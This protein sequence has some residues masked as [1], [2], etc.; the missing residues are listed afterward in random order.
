MSAG[1]FG[2]S[3]PG[4]GVIGGRKGYGRGAGLRVNPNSTILWDREVMLQPRV[5]EQTVNEGAASSGSHEIGLVLST[6]MINGSQDARMLIPALLASRVSTAVIPASRDS[7][8]VIPAT[9][10]SVPTLSI[11][12]V[13]HSGA[14]RVPS[15][16]H[17]ETVGR[18]GLPRD[19]P[20][21]HVNGEAV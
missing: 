20:L 16:V 1:G 2:P 11:P 13:S 12:R 6:T 9:I 3:A 5:S 21:S 8:S 4:A 18:W 19:A 15:V 10:V 14:L 17:V 7:T